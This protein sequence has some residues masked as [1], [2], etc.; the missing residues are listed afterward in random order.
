MCSKPKAKPEP[1]KTAEKKPQDAVS[2]LFDND[3]EEHSMVNLLVGWW[4][5]SGRQTTDEFDTTD[6][7]L[8]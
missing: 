6:I 8:S 4:V 1:S 2:A 3:D 5:V 7:L